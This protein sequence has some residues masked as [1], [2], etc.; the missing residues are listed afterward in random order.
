MLFNAGSAPHAESSPSPAPRAPSRAPPVR[1]RVRVSPAAADRGEWAPAWLWAV[2]GGLVCAAMTPLEP[3]LLEEG[4]MVHVG[5]RML[6]GDHL[7]R[8]IVLVTGPVPYAF[9]AALFA[10]FG[11]HILAARAGVVLLQALACG[12]VFA[13]A[14]RAGSGAWAHAAAACFASG[15]VLLFPLLSTMFYT[16]VATSLA[17]ITAYLGLRALTSTPWAVAAG[18][19]AALTAL[20]KQTVG[21]LLAVALVGAVAACAPRGRRLRRAAEVCAGGAAVAVLT[22]A[23]FASLGD[24]GDFVSSMVARPEG[25][26]F[27]FPFINLWP[28]GHLAP[29]LAGDE[30]YYVP[31]T[32]YLLRGGAKGVPAPLVLASQLLYVLPFAALALTGVRRLAGPLPAAIWLHAA[33]LLALLANLFPRTDAG[34]LVFVAPAAAAHLFVLAPGL[35]RGAGRRIARAGSAA[36]VLGL[37]LACAGL[38]SRLYALSH[39]PSYGPRVPLRPISPP[40]ASRAVPHTI[41]WLRERVTPGEPIFVA[42]A[43]PLIYFATGTRN[44]TPFTGALQVWGIRHEQQDE[45]LSALGDVRFV[46]MTDVDEPLYTYF[47]DELPEVE[48]YL[49]R[50]FHVPP[51]F[52][53][54]KRIDDWMLVLARGE[55]RGATAV[56]LLDPVREPAAWLRGRD[57]QRRPAKPPTR[58]L[59]TRHNRR[60]LALEI[61]AGGGGLDWTFTV[62]RGGR[63]QTSVGFRR[64]MSLRQ[65]DVATF[66]VSVSD[67]GPFEEVASQ[68]V[69]LRRAGTGRTWQD[70]DVDLSPWSGREITLRLEV[71]ARGTKKNG[72]ALLGSPRIA[73]PAGR[74]PADPGA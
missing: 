12:S 33:G 28:P 45:I 21:A 34:H 37:A 39:P 30:Y 51:G 19:A 26:T 31:E 17:V 32:V 22:L 62:P 8:D 18:V 10:V 6:A 25:E 2:L 73:L 61:A 44:P 58:D 11:K 68:R 48:A 56:D 14:R 72:Y 27:G 47:R 40:K 64:I 3:N 55:D 35:E 66:V 20:S 53:G 29:E 50:Y 24:L 67:G 16:T 38:G 65:P 1:G 7:Y 52:S 23:I 4:L 71:R 43:E 42:R 59:P 57:G 15:P 36:V 69:D 13:L 5:E 9:T 54:R 41:A 70:L 46:V 60:P 63:F 74:S 49:E